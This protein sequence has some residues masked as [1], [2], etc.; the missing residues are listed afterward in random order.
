VNRFVILS[1]ARSGTHLIGR[2]LQKHPEVV[3]HYELFMRAPDL[4]LLAKQWKV[5]PEDVIR[6][7]ATDVPAFLKT[8]AFASPWPGIAVAGFHLF[9]DQNAVNDPSQPWT[10][11]N[12]QGDIRIVH[13]IRRN[14][15]RRLLSLR[16]AIE[17]G[18]W[19]LWS[20][21]QRLGRSAEPPAKIEL[22]LRY[23]RSA[24]DAFK[25]QRDEARLRLSALP[26]LDLFY[27]DLIGD[28][29]NQMARLQ[30]FIGARRIDLPARTVKQGVGPLED[31]IGNFAELRAGLAGTEFAWMLED[32]E[33]AVAATV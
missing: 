4:P 12:Q 3:D 26:Q 11:L 18:N 8:Y 31:R 10:W 29:T 20:E 24:L 6:L 30:D 5:P 1:T 25:A 23:V 9:Y 21:N 33:N 22:K 15:L 28:F 16:T 2:A 27:E 7:H 13:L 14:Q 17:T 19:T 32:A